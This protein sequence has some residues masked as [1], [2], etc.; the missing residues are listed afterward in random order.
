MLADGVRLFHG[1]PAAGSP[2]GTGT[3]PVARALDLML[4]RAFLDTTSDATNGFEY[5]N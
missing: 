2:G 3:S 1:G 4:G 5:N